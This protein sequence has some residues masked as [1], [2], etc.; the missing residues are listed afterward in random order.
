LATVLKYAGK[1]EDPIAFQKKAISLNPF[2]PSIYLRNLGTAYRMSGRYKEAITAFRR[3]LENGTDY[4]VTHL[5]LAICYVSLGRDEKAR[6]AAEE[7]LP[8][9][10][11]FSLSYF[12]KTLPL[13]SKN[14]LS[15]FQ[16]LS[17]KIVLRRLS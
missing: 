8:I 16:L 2:P 11:E 5:G 17:D 13:S 6:A 7:V 3:A 4:L 14:I 15:L 12:A 9:Q 1:H 10:L